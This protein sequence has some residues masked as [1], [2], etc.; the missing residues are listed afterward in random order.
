MFLTSFP[1]FTAPRPSHGRGIGDHGVLFW[2]PVASDAEYSLTALLNALV[3]VLIVLLC[4]CLSLPCAVVHVLSCICM[5]MIA[6]DIP[7]LPIGAVFIPLRE[8]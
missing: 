2:A 5:P 3:L 6:P 7:S 8:G 4:C 1:L